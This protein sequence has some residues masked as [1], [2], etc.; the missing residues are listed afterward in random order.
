VLA[1]MG[2]AARQ[3]ARRYDWDTV[4]AQ[5]EAFYLQACER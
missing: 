3:W 4:A 2:M 5:Q 1:E